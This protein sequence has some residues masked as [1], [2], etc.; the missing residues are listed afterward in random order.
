[1]DQR[2][3]DGGPLLLAAGQFRGEMV[4]T[5]G[6]TDALEEGSGLRFALGPPDAGEHERQR[7]VFQRRQPGQQIERLEDETHSLPAMRREL[8]FIGRMQRQAA[9][10]D[11]TIRRPVQAAEQVEKCGFAGSGGADKRDELTASDRQVYLPESFYLRLAKAKPP[12][13]VREPDGLIHSLPEGFGHSQRLLG[14]EIA[15]HPEAH[16]PLGPG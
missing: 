1:M 9:R 7:H 11:L 4:Q 8:P 15:A 16:T 2:A 10:P 3:G 13:D 14:C 6:Q 5:V 12:T